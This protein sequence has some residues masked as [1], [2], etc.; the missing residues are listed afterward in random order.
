[1]SEHAPEDS[2]RQPRITRRNLLRLGGGAAGGTLIVG[3]ALGMGAGVWY[4][5]RAGYEGVEK[6]LGRS[7]TEAVFGNVMNDS[8]K[9]MI[10]DGLLQVDR[11]AAVADSIFGHASKREDWS[12]S[13]FIIAQR[14]IAVHGTMLRNI[15]D[16]DSDAQSR[17]D[18]V[19]PD[20]HPR[21]MVFYDPNGS[22]KLVYLDA[23]ANSGL[24]TPLSASA[25][26]TVSYE[27]LPVSN[28][29]IEGRELRGKQIYPYT[30]DLYKDLRTGKVVENY[31]FIGQSSTAI[32]ANDLNA[33]AANY[34]YGYEPVGFPPA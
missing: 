20:I 29:D 28:I 25:P 2:N 32:T 30:K 34:F 26:A 15:A 21:L 6:S 19:L 14:P 9:F 1:M 22:G 3:A 16:Y 8:H 17:V 7:D 11:E 24:V 10:Y 23:D 4:G 33:I 13:G 31:Y 12:Q 27:H 5:G 18:R